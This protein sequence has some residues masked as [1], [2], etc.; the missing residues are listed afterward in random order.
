MTAEP[1]L[2]IMSLMRPTKASLATAIRSATSCAMLILRQCIQRSMR[3]ASTRGHYFH[4]EIHNVLRVHTF[5]FHGTKLHEHV[6]LIHHRVST[7][8]LR[9]HAHASSQSTI[10]IMRDAIRSSRLHAVRTCPSDSRVHAAQFVSNLKSAMCKHQLSAENLL[11]K[12][13]DAFIIHR[14]SF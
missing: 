6:L 2:V 13:F 5:L 1:P 9:G 8:S 7:Y 4:E 12:R 3:H 14:T 11:Q 10:M